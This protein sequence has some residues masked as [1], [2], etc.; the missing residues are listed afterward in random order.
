MT[1]RT[2]TLHVWVEGDVSDVSYRLKDHEISDGQEWKSFHS[3]VSAGNLLTITV[4][5]GRH[6]SSAVATWFKDG[7][8]GSGSLCGCDTSDPEPNE[9]NFAFC[10]DLVFSY[11]GN[12]AVVNAVYFGQGHNSRGRNNWWAGLNIG[13]GNVLIPGHS[14]FFMLNRVSGAE[15]EFTLTFTIEEL[16]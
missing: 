7:V 2:N 14:L 3:S 13:S 11:K 15:N 9:L 5:A 4:E 8:A 10:G 1:V 12:Q 6:K 16:S